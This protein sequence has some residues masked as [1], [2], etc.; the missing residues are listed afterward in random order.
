[1][2]DSLLAP[3]G[4]KKGDT[5]ELGGN[6]SDGCF[7]EE[8]L[9]V[10]GSFAVYFGEKGVGRVRQLWAAIP[11]G[12]KRRPAPRPLFGTLQQCFRVGRPQGISEKEF[13]KRLRMFGPASGEERQR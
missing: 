3:E 12:K 9:R 11:P 8:S 10:P 4:L 6:W 1:V 5:V 7:D 13:E 2:E